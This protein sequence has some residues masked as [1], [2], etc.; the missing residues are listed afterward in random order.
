MVL[1]MPTLADFLWKAY[2][3]MKTRKS[4]LAIQILTLVKAF[5]DGA[6]FRNR[7]ERIREY[8]VWALRTGGPAYYEN[9][10]PISCKLRTDDPSYPVS[11]FYHQ[12]F[13]LTGLL[14]KPSGFLR[15]Q[16]ILPIAKTYLSFAAKSVL[17]PSLGPKNPPMGLYA[18]ILTAVR[19]HYHS[20]HVFIV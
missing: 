9:P 16:F 2:D 5:F 19:S 3:R 13:T 20:W 10:V 12:R 14:K 18:L 6:E 15:S 1:I 7:P 17:H 4:K 8:V 11:F